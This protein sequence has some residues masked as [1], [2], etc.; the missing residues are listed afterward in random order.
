VDGNALQGCAAVKEFD[1]P[2]LI[3]ILLVPV[4]TFLDNDK[5]FLRRLYKKVAAMGISST[6]IK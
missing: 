4:F 3:M 2:H 5:N 1:G 6:G